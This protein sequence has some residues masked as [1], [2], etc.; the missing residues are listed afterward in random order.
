[1]I[2]WKDATHYSRYDTERR[3]MAFRAEVGSLRVWVGAD[4]I[5][6]PGKWVLYCGPW[7]D[8]YDLMLPSTDGIEN[9]EAAQEK[10]LE[11]V[12]RKVAEAALALG[13]L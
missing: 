13:M 4:H 7:F 6:Y 8:T 9:R 2:D 12:R 10:A 1:M 5:H 11:L 3:P